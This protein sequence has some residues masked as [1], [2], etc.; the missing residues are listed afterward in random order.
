MGWL[1]G[2]KEYKGAVKKV[3]NGKMSKLQQKAQGDLPLPVVFEFNKGKNESQMFKDIYFGTALH[4]FQRIF[5]I[6]NSSTVF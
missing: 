5:L 6:V 2:E 3:G 4:G 1:L